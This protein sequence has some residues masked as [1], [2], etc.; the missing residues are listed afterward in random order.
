MVVG[1][2]IALRVDDETGAGRRTLAVF[3]DDVVERG[4][5]IPEWIAKSVG[6]QRADARSNVYADDGRLDLFD[7]VNDSRSPRL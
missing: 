3:W 7:C 4:E 5:E 6:T 1:E 2:N